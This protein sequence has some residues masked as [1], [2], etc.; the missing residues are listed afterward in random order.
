LSAALVADPYPGPRDG[1]DFSG[2]LLDAYEQN[3]LLASGVILAGADKADAAAVLT[4]E[5]VAGLDLRGA[6]L[7]VLSADESARGVGGP[8]QSPTGLARAFHEAGARSVLANLWRID[9]EAARVLMTN[10]Y[11]GLWRKKLSRL[12]AL[13]Q[14]QLFVIRNPGKVRPGAKVSRPLWW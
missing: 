5:E 10:F 13:R 11:D 3:P 7:V 4:A 14:A 9:G 12:E 2:G 8:W 6:D 1:W